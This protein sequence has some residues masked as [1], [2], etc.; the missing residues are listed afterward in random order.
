MDEGDETAAAEVLRAQRPGWEIEY[1]FWAWDW[2]W[3]ARKDGW[4][5]RMPLLARTVAGIGEK[6]A[7]EELQ[8]AARPS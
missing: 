1:G 2:L 8:E 6:I 3:S 4:K 5:Q 7:E